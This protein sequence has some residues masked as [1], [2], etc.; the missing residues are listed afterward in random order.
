LLWHPKNAILERL[1]WMRV[2]M[3]SLLHEFFADGAPYW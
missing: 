3:R 2:L 1:F